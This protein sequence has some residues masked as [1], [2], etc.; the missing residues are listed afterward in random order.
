[1]A[2]L[3][4][5]RPEAAEKNRELETAVQRA[6]D[7]STLPQVA[8]RVLELAKDPDAGASDLTAVVEGDPALSARVLK[9][10]NSAAYSLSSTITNLHQAISYLGFSQI[11]NLALTASVAEIFRGE[12]IIGT[13]DRS[14]LWRHMVA[15]GVCSRL[16]ATRCGIANFEDAFLAGLLHD[17]GLILA[18]QHDHERFRLT[19]LNLVDNQ[20]LAVSEQKCL[21]YTH[22]DL[23]AR[24]AELWRFPENVQAAIRFHHGSQHYHGDHVRL[25]NCVEIANVICTLKGISSVGMQLLAPPLIALNAVGFQK[26]DVLVLA[27]D[28]DQELES[29]RCL[30]EL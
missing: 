2:R 15:V 12:T 14:N 29:S 25:V 8:L 24:I 9:V 17:I 5:K 3:A 30:M 26:E 20:P 7:V 22:C 4:T 16:V 10:I 18:D 23:G 19:M 1:M 6:T 27:N 11:R 28:L 21:G 13:Y